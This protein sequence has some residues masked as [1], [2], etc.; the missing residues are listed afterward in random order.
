VRRL[1]Q[2]GA[3]P[4]RRFRPGRRPGT[5]GNTSFTPAEEHACDLVTLAQAS[6]ALSLGVRSATQPYQGGCSYTVTGAT[7]PGLIVNV[8]PVPYSA[9]G[10]YFSGQPA[11]ASGVGHLAVC[12][13]GLADPINLVAEIDSGHTLEIVGPS[14]G[15]D[16]KIAL[17]AYSRLAG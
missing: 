5:S 8:F 3:Q 6:A 12:G 10:P 13:P 16:T 7:S 1:R 15:V 9:D 14:C 4:G 11:T 17:E 2:F